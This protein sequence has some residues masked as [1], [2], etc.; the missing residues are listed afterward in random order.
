MCGSTRVCVCH[1]Q[2]LFYKKRIIIFTGYKK[3]LV[4]A[5]VVPTDLEPAT[6]QTL[7]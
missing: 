6:S 2:Q 7:Q 4:G 3:F 5:S 1:G